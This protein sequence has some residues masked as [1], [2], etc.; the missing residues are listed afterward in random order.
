[1]IYTNTSKRY[2]VVGYDKD[3]DVFVE[4]KFTDDPKEAEDFA[5][6]LTAVMNRGELRMDVTGE[7]L[8][9]VEIYKHWGEE[10]EEQIWAS[11]DLEE[12]KEL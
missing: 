9:W 8:D 5:L 7:P 11:Y 2:A 6:H 3:N 4:Y 10:N 1:M 12:E